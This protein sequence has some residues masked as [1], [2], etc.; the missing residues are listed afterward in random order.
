MRKIREIWFFSLLVLAT[1]LVQNASATLVLPNSSFAQ[2]QHNWQGDRV[3]K[4]D[5]FHVLIDFAVYDTQLLNPDTNPDESDLVD[6]LRSE[7]DLPGQYIYAYQIFNHPDALE[8]VGYFEIFGIG[9]PP[10]DVYADSVGALSDSDDPNLEGIKPTDEYFNPSHTRGTWL[11]SADYGPGSILSGEHSWL[12]VFSSDSA[13]VPGSYEIKGPEE[14][15]FPASAPS[16]PEPGTLMLLGLGG[17]L[18][19]TKRRKSVQ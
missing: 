15:E 9:E 6:T 18:I 4:Q 2:E 8:E 19:L 13:P 3:Y 1:L 5:G 7:L 14:S 16:T 11:F 12:L 10:L 17:T